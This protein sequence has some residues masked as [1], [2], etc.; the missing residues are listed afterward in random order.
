MKVID[1]RM[2]TADGELREEYRELEERQATPSAGGSEPSPPPVEAAAP[3]SAESPS[4]PSV[5]PPPEAVAAPPSGERPSAPEGEARV[6]MPQTPGSLRP[7]G[8][9]ELISVLAEPI[10]IYLGDAKMPDGSSAENP[11][12]ARFYIDLLEVLQQKTAGNL[13]AQ[14]AAVLEDLLY[15]LRMRYVRQRG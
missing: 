11:E 7:P 8:F 12:A 6:E 13:S 4:E 5:E 2:F 14:E 1:K 15:Q 10:A 3:Q 9:M